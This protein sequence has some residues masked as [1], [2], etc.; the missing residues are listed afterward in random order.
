MVWSIVLS[1]VFMCVVALWLGFISP[2]CKARIYTNHWAVR[3]TGGPGFADRIAE[4]YGY[5]NMGQV[6][7]FRLARMKF[8]DLIHCAHVFA[9]RLL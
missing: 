1:R 2:L 3:I 4:K 9:N 7:L 6:R 8:F 5:K